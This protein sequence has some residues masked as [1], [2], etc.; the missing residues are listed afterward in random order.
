M[1]ERVNAEAGAGGS[2]PPSVRHRGD[3]VTTGTLPPAERLRHRRV[4]RPGRHLALFLAGVVVT[5]CLAG[6]LWFWIVPLTTYA[7]DE[8]GNATVTERGLAGI[9][10]AD[11]W[12]ALLGVVL[13]VI[14]GLVVW[15]WFS[16]LGWPCVFLAIVG[17]LVMAL[18]CWLV[19]SQL[20][21][22]PFNERLAAAT[23]GQTLPIE[24]TLR[25][26]AALLIWPFA[27][28]LVLMLISALVP[29]PE[30]PGAE[31]RDAAL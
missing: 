24:L 17:S 30:D 6:V 22:G 14:C 25:A 15:S 4:A 19:G 10:A 27:A 29:D 7:V 23:P 16:G 9:V 3:S 13:G 28:V 12:F 31:G 11:A 5:G 21:P 1:S 8:A 26:P 2:G 18:L 20:G